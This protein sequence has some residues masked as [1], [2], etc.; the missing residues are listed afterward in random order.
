MHGS[1]LQSHPFCD[2]IIEAFLVGA[3]IC[4]AGGRDTGTLCR[5]SWWHGWDGGRSTLLSPVGKMKTCDLTDDGLT[6]HCVFVSKAS[7]FKGG[8]VETRI[9]EGEQFVRTTYGTSDGRRERF[10]LLVLASCV[11]PVTSSDTLA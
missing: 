8:D 1:R 11:M 6:Y 4:L 7:L 3:G 5:F 9:V 10:L 2:A